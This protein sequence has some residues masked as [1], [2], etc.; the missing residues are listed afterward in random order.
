MSRSI[1]FFVPVEPRGKPRPRFNR[2]G[3]AFNHPLVEF[4]EGVIREKAESAMIGHGPLTGPLAMSLT[5]YFKPPA[6]RKIQGIAWH[7]ARPDF[8]NLLKMV[9]D[10][11]NKIVYADDGAIARCV[12]E[13]VYSTAD[14][15]GFSVCFTELE[16]HV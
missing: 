9:A 3:G 1:A 16:P 11:C 4:V 8:D 10:A 13:K 7:T 5:V 6:S 14:P 15:E 12:F 2:H